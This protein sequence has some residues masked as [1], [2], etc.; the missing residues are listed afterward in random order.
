[1][2]EL[3][4]NHASLTPA[5]ERELVGWL[6]DLAGGIRVLVGAG[7]TQKVVRMCRWPHEIDCF[8]GGSLGDAYNL[9]LKKGGRTRE[10][11][12][13]L[14]GLS[15]KA[16]LLSGVSSDVA[17]RFLRCEG[18]TLPSTDGEPLVFC[19]VTEA[20]SVGFPSEPVWE[21]DR[22]TVTFLKLLADGTFEDASEVIDNLTCIGHADSIVTRH[23]DLLRFYCADASELWRRRA[24]L[25]PHLAFGSDVEGHLAKLNPGLLPTLV[26][27]LAELDETAAAWTADGGDAPAWTCKV[28]PESESLMN[29]EKLRNAR[30]F[31]S[32][33]GERL[34]FEWHARFGGGARI[35]LR[36]DARKREIEIGYIGVHLPSW[37]K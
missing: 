3:V 12:A 9:L 15:T 19:A 26:N 24:E 4:L 34:L 20:I 22:L 28:T 29:N 21:R 8:Q 2:R 5:D 30:R 18:K 25:F 16:P 32:V 7:L 23:R 33:R 6:D 31:R 11:A 10:V 17:D 36:F 35:H 13:Y 37:K 27:R 14:R 1:M